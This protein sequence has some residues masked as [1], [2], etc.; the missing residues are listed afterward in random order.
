MLNFGL[1]LKDNFYTL[2]EYLF[3]SADNF[4]TQSVQKFC[5]KL[6][7]FMKIFSF[8]KKFMSAEI[9]SR[10]RYFLSEHLIK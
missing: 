9:L 2:P 1:E 8:E 6:F 10:V 5:E 7:V 3:M 4:T